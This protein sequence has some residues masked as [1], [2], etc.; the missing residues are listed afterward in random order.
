MKF[1]LIIMTVASLAG[2]VAGGHYVHPSLNQAQVN[3]L[4]FECRYKAELMSQSYRGLYSVV[5]FADNYER[6][7]QAN[8]FVKQ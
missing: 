3:Q 2:C 1:I 4:G 8:G 7:L 5:S 6:C